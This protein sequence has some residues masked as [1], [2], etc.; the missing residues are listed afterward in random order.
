M[1]VHVNTTGRAVRQIAAREL[2]RDDAERRDDEEDRAPAERLDEHAADARPHRR[3][4]HHAEAEHAHRLALLVFLKRVQ[5]DDRGN[6]LQH[7]GAQPFDDAHREHRFESL[8]A[9]TGDAADQQ[10]HDGAAVGAAVAEALEQPR[11]RQHRNRHRRHEPGRQPLRA[12]LAQGEAPAHVGHRD[13]DDR[14]RHDRRH[15]ADHHRQQNA[16]A[17][18]LAVAFA[19]R[20]EGVRGGGGANT[21]S[22]LAPTALQR[23]A[24]GAV[25][26]CATLDLLVDG[27]QHGRGHR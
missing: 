11:G 2:E 16:P 19:Q 1:R 6:R 17:I 24:F 13:V 3:R 25:V 5:H 14:R 10:Q 4:Q 15:R 20:G 18:A 23:R 26:E 27:A 22:A 12:L 7:A 9:A 21:K 8:A